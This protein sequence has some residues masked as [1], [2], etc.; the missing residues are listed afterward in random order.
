MRLK[1]L[2]FLNIF[3][4]SVIIFSF[5]N[6]GYNHSNVYFGSIIGCIYIL[7]LAEAHNFNNLEKSRRVKDTEAEVT[8]LVPVYREGEKIKNSIKSLKNNPYSNIQIKII[9]EEDDTETVS[10]ARK[11]E[12]KNTEVLINNS[13]IKSKAA[14]LNYG[15]KNSNSEY[16]AIFDSDQIIPQDFFSRGLPF[17]DNYNAYQARVMSTPTNL[18]SKICYYE[19]LFYT[20]GAKYF[21]HKFTGRSQPRTKAV[22]FERRSLAKLDGFREDVLTEDIEFGERFTRNGYTTYKDF[23]NKP[24]VESSPITFRDWIGHRIRWTTGFVDTLR[25]NKSESDIKNLL[26]LFGVLIG[27]NLVVFMLGQFIRFL[28]NLDH[29]H[30][31]APVFVTAATSAGIKYKD[32]RQENIEHIG[33]DWILSAFVFPLMSVT[34]TYSIIK[35]LLGRET[36]W[37][38]IDKAPEKHDLH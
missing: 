33:Y 4:T 5:L 11:L 17:L 24:V 10:E 27:L 21:F 35:R 36:K 9:C 38:R 6:I 22:I 31:L 1:P 16:I 18:V 25:S 29:L 23:N 34:M 26:G 8:A 37:Y 7:F 32:H 28:T 30:I 19:E 15:L 12:D 14:A 20:D 2:F 13:N 3:L